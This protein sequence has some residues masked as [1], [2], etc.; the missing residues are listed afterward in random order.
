LTLCACFAPAASTTLRKLSSRWFW[1]NEFF[2]STTPY[3][4]PS[5]SPSSTTQFAASAP[6]FSLSTPTKVSTASSSSFASMATTLMPCSRAA[7]TAGRTP[8]TSIATTMIALTPW[9]TK[10]SMSLFCLAE[11]LF[12][13]AICSSQPA[14]S[15]ASCAPSFIW[16]KNTAVW[17]ICV[18]PMLHS[19]LDAVLSEDASG[20][21][22]LPVLQPA[23]RSALAARATTPRLASSFG[24]RVMVPPA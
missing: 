11:S 20:S 13:L 23:S 17:L 18:I 21:V 15:A 16:V 9:D 12:A 1:M 6:A 4:L 8:F 10:F 22:S 2:A 24:N 19:S 7:L 5:A 14:F 3:V